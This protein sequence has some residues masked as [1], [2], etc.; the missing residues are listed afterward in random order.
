MPTPSVEAVAC[1]TNRLIIDELDY[2][3]SDEVSRFESLARGLNSYQYRIFRSMVD[4]HHRGEEGLFFLHSR[5]G[6]GKTYL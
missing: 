3:M 6:T 4:T 2:D 1:A 5:G